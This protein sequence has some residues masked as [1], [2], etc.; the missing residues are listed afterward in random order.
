ME[1]NRQL[2]TAEL[3]A[4]LRALVSPCMG[5]SDINQL[6]KAITGLYLQA[7]YPASRPYLRQPPQDGETLDITLV[8]GFVESIELAGADLPLSL[9]GAFPGCS[10]TRCT[11]RTWSKASTNSTACAP[12]I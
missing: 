8:E 4:T 2:D 9:A 1:G 7:G 11:C 10:A 6:L 3:T 12:T 5:V